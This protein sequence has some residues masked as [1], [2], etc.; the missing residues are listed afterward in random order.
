MGMYVPPDVIAPYCILSTQCSKRSASLLIGSWLPW[1][2]APVPAGL[3]NAHLL[4][5]WVSSRAEHVHKRR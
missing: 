2:V 3:L 4:F 1:I 5:L